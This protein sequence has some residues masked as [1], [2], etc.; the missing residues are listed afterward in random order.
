M[1]LCCCEPAPPT[2]DTEALGLGPW[3][4]EE[5]EERLRP[6]GGTDVERPPIERRCCCCWAPEGEAG[7]P[8]WL[9]PPTD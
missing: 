2:A 4:G 5:M 9:S 3:R 6:T 8:W 7:L 1:G